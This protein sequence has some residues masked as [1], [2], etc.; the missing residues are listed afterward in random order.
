MDKSRAAS[1]GLTARAAIAGLAC[2]CACS[3]QPMDL[4]VTDL[5]GLQLTGYADGKVAY[6]AGVSVCNAGPG[7]AA[8]VASTNQHPL[9]GLGVYRLAAG[10]FEQVGVSW[11]RHPSL[12]IAHQ[13]GDC[14]GVGGA[15]LGA[16]CYDTTSA[17][18]NAAQSWLGPRGEVNASTGDFPFP[19]SDPQG[20]TGN[21]IFKR[22]QATLEDM[23]DT[24]AR[25]YFE[26]HVVHPGE[27]L[28]A[29]E[30]NAT[31]RRA[32]IM[33]ATAQP[34]ASGA[35]WPGRA[36][37]YAWRDDGLGPNEPD[38]SVEVSQVRVP[39]DGL[40]LLASRGMQ[41]PGGWRYIYAIENVSSHRGV[42]SLRVAG[43]GAH[44][45]GFN[46]VDYH[47]GDTIDGTDWVF[48]NAGAVSWRAAHTHSQLPTANAIRFGTMYT[49]W[50]DSPLPPVMGSATL[51]LFRPG[52]PQT[53]DAPAW[54]P[55]TCDPDVNADGNADQDDVAYLITVIGGGANPTGADPDFNSDGNADQDDVSALIGVV[56]GG[57]CP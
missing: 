37:I 38:P 21:A 49:F 54:V 45:P 31:Y 12:A 8:Y 40:V 3:A 33:P 32:N 20:P 47:S 29:R 10:R 9:W 56:A 4:V 13:C 5:P 11:L 41:V 39:D 1:R 42:S 46:D 23:S 28:G 17:S 44:S 19:F 22:C 43:P 52:T 27:T 50:F 24:G 2:A 55:R 36:A 14:N 7:D 51:G 15:A 26:A 18:A 16:G 48:D 35:V 57:N 25:Y 53:I 30:N 34:V 6:A